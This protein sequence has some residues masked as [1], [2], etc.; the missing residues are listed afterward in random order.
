VTRNSFSD[1][2]KTTL[3]RENRRG[4][5]LKLIGSAAAVTPRER[6]NPGNIP[7][8][9]P[10]GDDLSPSLRAHIG[11]LGSAAATNT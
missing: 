2:E 4:T 3:F 11:V 6:L 10:D 5:T 7:R 1:S 9:I 8:V